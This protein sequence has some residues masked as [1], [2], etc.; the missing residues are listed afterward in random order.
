[1]FSIGGYTHE[2]E[3]FSK[4]AASPVIRARFAQNV[5]GM[6]NRHNFDGMDL[7]WEYPAQRGGDPDNDKENF[8]LL[9]AE[10]YRVLHAAGKEFGIAVAAAEFSASI[11]YDVPRLSPV[12]DFINIMT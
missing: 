9:C 7:D 6:I 10:L 5:L 1:M 3:T 4:I 11:S 8:V 2:S 12:V